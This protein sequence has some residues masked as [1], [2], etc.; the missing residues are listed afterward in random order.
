MSK[1]KNEEDG[2]EEIYCSAAVDKSKPKWRRFEDYYKICRDEYQS[3]WGYLYSYLNLI[4]DMVQG[5]NKTVEAYIE[6]MLTQDVVSELMNNYVL[7]DMEMPIIRIMHYLYA[8]SQRYYPIDRITRVLN[9]NTLEDNIRI[10]CSQ[11]E[12]RPKEALGSTMECLIR[13]L[14][15]YGPIDPAKVAQNECLKVILDFIRETF[16]LG[17]WEEKKNVRRIFKSIT[18]IIK[19]HANI[20]Y[21]EIR[22]QS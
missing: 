6:V 14:K 1:R 5:R 10:N 8:E 20:N 12:I 11:G 2:T 4:A 19:P 18:R 9:Y 7:Y 15:K 3:A 16:L 22:E 21:K 13:K 17:F